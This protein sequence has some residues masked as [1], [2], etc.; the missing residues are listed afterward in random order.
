MEALQLEKLEEPELRK[1][2]NNL[3]FLK[4]ISSFIFCISMEQQRV[5]LLV[6]G[7]VQGVF[8]RQALKVVAKKN[9][10][11]GWVRNLKDMRVEVV[12]EGDNKSVN[13]VIAWA[14]IGPANSRVDDIE[15]SN[16][17]FKNEFLTFEV[18]Y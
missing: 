2:R 13:S 8:F 12:L 3:I 14:R 4:L 6:S 7:K 17:G 11:S 10:V 9:N 1:E 5:R 16:E 18:L 15:V